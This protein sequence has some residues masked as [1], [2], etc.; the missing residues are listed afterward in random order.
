MFSSKSN[1]VV[2]T[3]AVISP[4]LCC[5]LLFFCLPTYTPKAAEDTVQSSTLCLKAILLTAIL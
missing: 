5:P 4:L 3:V 2:S 1:S